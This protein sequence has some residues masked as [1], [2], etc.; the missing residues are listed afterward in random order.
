MKDTEL[1]P[2]SGSKEFD[3]RQEFDLSKISADKISA[4]DAKNSGFDI[5]ARAWLK[6]HPNATK[7][8][9]DKFVNK[10]Y[11]E[12]SATAGRAKAT[13]VKPHSERCMPWNGVAARISS[14]RS[15]PA[16]LS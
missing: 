16:P 8:K 5:V 13:A 14:A 11:Y 12:R 9:K 1:T 15:V 4:D 10:F 3:V 6:D 2:S 7:A